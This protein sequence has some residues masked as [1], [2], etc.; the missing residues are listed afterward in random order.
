MNQ[1]IPCSRYGNLC[2]DVDIRFCAASQL[3]IDDLYPTRCNQGD[4]NIHKISA[5]KAALGPGKQKY[6]C[7][8]KKTDAGEEVNFWEEGDPTVTRNGRRW[9]PKASIKCGFYTPRMR[10]RFGWPTAVAIKTKLGEY[11]MKRNGVS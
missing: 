1:D 3:T 11:R 8:A 5:W 10:V 9:K 7:V 2:D 4:E 6:P